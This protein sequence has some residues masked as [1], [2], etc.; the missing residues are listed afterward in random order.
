M[1][2]GYEHVTESRFC[3]LHKESQT[4][5]TGAGK[6]KRSRRFLPILKNPFLSSVQAGIVIKEESENQQRE[7]EVEDGKPSLP[8]LQRRKAEEESFPTVSSP[9]FSII[10]QNF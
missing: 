4:C 6:G 10:F 3:C 1:A 5:E 8:G 7:Q 2:T 9:H